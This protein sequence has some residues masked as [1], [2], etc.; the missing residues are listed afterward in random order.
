MDSSHSFLYLPFCF[1]RFDITI[2]LHGPEYDLF[3]W[4]LDYLQEASTR[5]AGLSRYLSSFVIQFLLS[6]PRSSPSCCL[7]LVMQYATKNSFS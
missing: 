5:V 2:I 6:N 3:V 4:R 7:G 1:G